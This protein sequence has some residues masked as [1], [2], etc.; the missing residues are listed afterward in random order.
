MR[1]ATA[2]LTA[3]VMAASTTLQVAPARAQQGPKMNVIRDAEIEQLLRDYATPIFDTAGIRKGSIQIILLGN[4]SFNAFVADGKRMFIN[5]G[6][7]MEAKTP[8]EVIGVIAHETGH[9]VGGH[10]ARLR[11]EMAKAQLLAVAG[12]LLGAGAI[13][14]GAASR[15][16]IGN[17]GTGAA[18]AMYGGQEMAMR[19]LLAYQRSEEQAADRMAVTYLEKTGQSPRGMLDTFRRFSQDAMFKT[20]SIDPYLLSHPLPQERIAN[21]EALA[22]KSPFLSRK[23]PPALQARHDMMRAKLFGFAGNAAEVGRRYP[24]SDTSLPGRYARA[25]SAYQSKRLPDALA[26][27]DALLAEQP[28]NPWFWELKGQVLLEFGRP[29]EALAPLRRAVSLAPSA[30][31]VRILLGQALVATGNKALAPEAIRELSNATQ[32]EAEWPDGWRHLAQAYAL[33]GDIGMAEYASA[34]A[35]FVV[36]DFRM[37][38]TQ[39]TRAKEKL[40]PGSPSYLKSEDIINHRPARPP[41]SDP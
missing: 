1:R 16:A 11:Q 35:Y 25:I 14:G 32:R 22:N 36:G 26:Q 39:A 18:G 15:G 37:A 9:I 31:L 6:T 21:M 20:S 10:L 23:D 34:Q 12:M 7:L 8:N 29:Q 30:G 41:M 28:A 4:R 5:I 38:V 13:A 2:A 33:K 3:L 17:A 40:P 24:L 19:S 27:I